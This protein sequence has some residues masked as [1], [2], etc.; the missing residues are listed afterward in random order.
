MTVLE[1][2]NQAVVHKEM[3]ID[4]IYGR[5]HLNEALHILA[6]LY[7]SA[8]VRDTETVICSNTSTY[9]PLSADCIKV[10]RVDDSDGEEYNKLFYSLD[11]SYIK[12]Q[13]TDTYLV[14]YLRKAVAVTLDTET[15]EI[16]NLYHR[17]ISKYIAHKE[18]RTIK[19]KDAADYKAE[20]FQE[21]GTIDLVLKNAK[22]RGTGTPVRQFR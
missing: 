5:T 14:T 15:P 1:I 6:M 4:H 22:K 11:N 2:I 8:K 9:Y 13:D 3:S 20:F 17:T 16:N 12:F 18:L 7:D 19:L 21:A 10:L